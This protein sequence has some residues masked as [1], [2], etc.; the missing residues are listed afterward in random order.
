MSVS[1]MPYKHDVFSGNSL[2]LSHS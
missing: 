2:C 1:V